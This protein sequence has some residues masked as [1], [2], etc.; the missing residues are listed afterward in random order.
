[1]NADIRATRVEA[2]GLGIVLI[3]FLRARE[4]CS[5]NVMLGSLESR[6]FACHTPIVALTRAR[7]PSRISPARPSPISEATA[8][9]RSSAD[10]VVTGDRREA[11]FLA[12]GAIVVVAA[13]ALPPCIRRTR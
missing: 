7:S 9:R 8:R 10:E 1:M 11:P 12:A 3:V 13:F 2:S 6:E 5:A 4:Y